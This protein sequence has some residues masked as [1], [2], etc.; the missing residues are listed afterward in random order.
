M[1]MLRAAACDDRIRAFVAAG[2]P[3]SSHDF[4]DVA[5]CK[6]PKLFVQG[7]LDQ[8]G[9]VEALQQLFAAMDEPKELKIIQT[10]D[11]FFE[12][13]L[14]ELAAAVSSFIASIA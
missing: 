1:V 4:S 2:V 12:G 8:F 6:K 14:P 3:V 9:A 5:Q 11:H 7:S 10:A 13:H